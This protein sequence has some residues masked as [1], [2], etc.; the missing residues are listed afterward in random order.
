MR[1]SVYCY[2]LLLAVAAR[3][4]V[5]R[6]LDEI[7]FSSPLQTNSGA[8]HGREQP[9]VAYDR[10]ASP[11][12]V[13]EDAYDSGDPTEI[14]GDKSDSTPILDQTTSYQSNLKSIPKPSPSPN[15]EP[16]PTSKASDQKSHDESNPD[17]SYQ[18][19]YTD[20]IPRSTPSQDLSSQETPNQPYNGD[21]TTSPKQQASPELN[22]DP[23]YKPTPEPY[24]QDS[25]AY[26]SPEQPSMPRTP[27]DYAV[28]ENILSPKHSIDADSPLDYERTSQQ[29]IDDKKPN[30][31]LL[32]NSLPPGVPTSISLDRPIHTKANPSPNNPSPQP[33]AMPYS[34]ENPPNS[35]PTSR[36]T[37]QPRQYP[38]PSPTN[39]S[40]K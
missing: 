20:S 25:D 29:Q 19:T 35:P 34:Q 23:N 30:P 2:F 27:A 37:L 4:S 18:P 15:Y 38:Q 31:P 5:R 16:S 21:S 24:N 11:D 36:T 9:S 3:G 7:A 1:D 6:S 33:T 8:E 22:T 39:C 13:I 12:A 40:A 26:R 28:P 10:A 32:S 17:S 14:S